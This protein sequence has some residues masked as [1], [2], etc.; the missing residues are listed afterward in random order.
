[1]SD[2]RGAFEAADG[3][4]LFLDEIG[5]LP[6]ELQPKLLRAL[7]RARGPPRRRRR[8]P[9]AVDVRIVA[10]TNRDLRAEVNRGRFREDL[11]YRLAVIALRLPPLRERREDIPLL[12]EHFCARARPR[13]RRAD[14]SP[15]ARAV[16]RARR[17]TAG[18]ATC[19]SCAT[20]SS[21]RSPA[22]GRD[23]RRAVTVGGDLRGGAR[24]RADAF[25]RAFLTELLQRTRGNVS[26]A[27]RRA[28]MDRVHLTK[29][30]GKHKLKPQR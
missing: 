17:A 20:A 13:D 15:R 14:G 21:A 22:L 19:A 2:R 6:L 4:T 7:E 28:D 24:R 29:L 26:E 27:A 5:E 12:V 25:E 30:L 8:R 3:G 23:H 9:R 16:A 10:A 18:R 11:Y 1:M